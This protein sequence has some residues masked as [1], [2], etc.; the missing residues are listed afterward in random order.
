M[1][2]IYLHGLNV[3]LPQNSYGK[4]LTPKEIVFGSGVFWEKIN[5]RWSRED[6]V[7]TVE[8]VSL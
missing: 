4:A 7:P 8:L 6:G 3:C 1:Q 2:P 5:F